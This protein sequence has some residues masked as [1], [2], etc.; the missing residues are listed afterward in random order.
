MVKGVANVWD[1]ERALDFYQDTLGFQPIKRDGPWAEIDAAVA[2][3]GDKGVESP[4]GISEHD[5]GRIA[6][7]KDSERDDLQLCESPRS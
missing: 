4:A 2:D 1:T 7:F 3:F 6:T 5:W